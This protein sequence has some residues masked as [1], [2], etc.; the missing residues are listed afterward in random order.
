[1]CTGKSWRL[2]GCHHLA[3]VIEGVKSTD[4]T[5]VPE[6]GGRQGRGMTNAPWTRFDN[7]SP[8]CGSEPGRAAR[9][10]TMPTPPDILDVD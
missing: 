8:A 3:K 6:R 1:M 7:G 10:V 4:G 9:A 5:G 2:R